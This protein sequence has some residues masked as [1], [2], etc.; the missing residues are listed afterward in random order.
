MAHPAAGS[1]RSQADS[2]CAGI[3]LDPSELPYINCVKS[4]M[5]LSQ[6]GQPTPPDLVGRTCV[7][8]GFAPGSQGYA[9]CVGNLNSSIEGDPVFGDWP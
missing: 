5:Q 9:S 2:A 7:R 8:A 3:G 6:V 4:F 1:S